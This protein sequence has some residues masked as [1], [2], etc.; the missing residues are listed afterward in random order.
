MCMGKRHSLEVKSEI[1]KKIREGQ[2]VREVAQAHEVKET[3]V[4]S[5]L[6]KNHKSASPATAELLRLKRENMALTELIGKLTV[7]AYHLENNHRHTNAQH[8]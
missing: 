2:S 3:T 1:L 8:P 7:Q 5:W 6:A 4:R